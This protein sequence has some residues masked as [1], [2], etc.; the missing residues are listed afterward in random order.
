M[1]EQCRGCRRIRERIAQWG[2][3]RLWYHIWCP[4]PNCG[5]LYYGWTATKRRGRSQSHPR[6]KLG[7]D[8]R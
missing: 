8:K 2:K 6:G 7:L 5:G 4:I 3:S 1:T